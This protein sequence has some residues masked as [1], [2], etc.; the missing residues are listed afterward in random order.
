MKEEP[1]PNSHPLDFRYAL[2][3]KLRDL[4]QRRPEAIEAANEIV[5]F[6]LSSGYAKR[7]DV[8][9]ECFRAASDCGCNDPSCSR[10]Q[11]IRTCEEIREYE[12]ALKEPRE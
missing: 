8:V 10:A 9:E 6:F 2:A 7:G 12:R 11:A 5:S 4:H 3:D 1:G